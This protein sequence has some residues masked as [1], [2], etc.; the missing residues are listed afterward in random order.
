[1]G[2]DWLEPPNDP[3][4]VLRA[5]FRSSSPGCYIGVQRHHMTSF[6][7]QRWA[8]CCVRRLKRFYPSSN[9]IF[10]SDYSESVNYPISSDT[11]VNF[12]LPDRVRG[13]PGILFAPRISPPQYGARHIT[14]APQKGLL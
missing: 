10:L 3:I 13:L 12:R 2:I 14:M 6:V 1:M 8:L 11:R 4:R 9:C 5:I 7:A